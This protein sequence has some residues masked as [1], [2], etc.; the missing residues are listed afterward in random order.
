MAK[1]RMGIMAFL[2]CLCIY[3]LP[4]HVNAAS[5]AGAKEP[6]I[7][8][9][10][11]SLN[12]S[13]RCG[14]ADFSGLSIKLYKI[15][16]VSADYQYTLD[17]AF[18]GSGLILNG[19]QTSGEWGVI[20][21]TLETYIFINEIKPDFTVMTDDK[22]VAH[23][24]DLKPGLY[25]VASAQEDRYDTIYVFYSTLVSVP[26]LNENGGWEYD[27]SVATKSQFIPPVEPD[28]DVEFKVVKLWKGEKEKDSRP[29]SVEVEIYR[30]GTIYQ[31]VSLSENNNWTFAWLAAEDG[32]DWKVVER[33]VPEGYN[34]TI[35][36]R[37]NSFIL[38]NTFVGKGPDAPSTPD[39]GD[40]SN[41]ML[42]II[43]MIVSGA[44]L[45]V[46]GVTGKRK[47]E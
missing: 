31:T 12:V 34:M 5:T 47:S 1:R 35:D 19:V 8:D 42:Y 25:L 40:S 2:L 39:T 28:K 45:I 3:L 41:I 11:C 43:L 20:R 46:L 37:Q 22:G 4:S 23:F 18:E 17:S 14:G 33:K 44:I 16:D 21:S 38:T 6:I 27:V 13:Y 15:A 10:D 9:A 7:T 26:N 32:S 30:N 29:K 36:E 24:E